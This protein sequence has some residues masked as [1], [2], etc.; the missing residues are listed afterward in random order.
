MKLN[1]QLN[2]FT[3]SVVCSSLTPSVSAVVG[4]MPTV[5]AP[6]S[7]PVVGEMPTVQAPQSAP[8]VGE[9]PTVQAPQSATALLPS[10]CT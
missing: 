3:L 10:L 4:E 7:A 5:Q 9:M 8:V 2:F 1:K 6:Q